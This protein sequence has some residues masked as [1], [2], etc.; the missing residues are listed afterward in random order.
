MN[1]AGKVFEFHAMS[2]SWIES[3]ANER[4]GSNK[5]T[6]EEQEDREIELEEKS[7]KRET[8]RIQ[9]EIKFIKEEYEEIDR[10]MKLSEE[11]TKNLSDKVLL[12]LSSK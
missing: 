1:L 9:N 3:L 5:P 10:K 4:G 2:L 6:K 12:F 8:K 11:I 7:C